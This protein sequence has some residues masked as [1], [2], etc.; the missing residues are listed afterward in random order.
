MIM[1]RREHW[2]QVYTTKKDDAVSWHQKEASLSLELIRQCSL[3]STAGV[4]DVG[5]GASRLVDGL[6]ERGFQDITVLDISEQAL[7][8]AAARLGAVGANVSWVPADITTYTP[9]RT[10]DLWHDRAVFHFL[11]SPDDRAVY[12]QTLTTA[13]TPGAHAIVSTFALHGPERCSG[14]DVARYDAE[15]LVRALGPAFDLVEAR[16]EAHTTPWGSVQAFTF[17]RVRRR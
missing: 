8:T 17:V 16:D 10:F 15:G 7:S 11:T 5:G 13:L 1:D 12:S 14:L 6:I 4:I 9:V 2:N 3:P